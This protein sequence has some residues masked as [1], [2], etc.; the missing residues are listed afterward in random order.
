M[1]TTQTDMMILNESKYALKKKRE[2]DL[3]YVKNF[4]P[5]LLY[6]GSNYTNVCVYFGRL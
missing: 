3:F 1:N 5:P 6:S 4:H 2:K